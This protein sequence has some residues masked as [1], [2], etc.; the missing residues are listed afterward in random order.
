MGLYKIL[1]IVAGILGIAGL[2]FW[3]LLLSKGDEAVK[4][5]GEGVSPLLYIAYIVMAITLVF[6]VIF[7]IQGIF[8]GNLKKTLMS[9]GAFLLILVIAYVM[10]SGSTEGLRPVDNTPITESTSKWVGTGLNAFYILAVLAVVSMIYSGF[11]K[12]KN[13]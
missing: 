11:T 6:V 3:F 13:R 4:A 5:T 2:V 1:K 7:V 8:H 9:I 12:V 10:A